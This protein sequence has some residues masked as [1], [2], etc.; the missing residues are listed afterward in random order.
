LFNVTNINVIIS[1]LKPLYLKEIKMVYFE[2]LSL[3]SFFSVLCKLSIYKKL[4]V[5]Y[6][7]DASFFANKLLIPALK[8]FGKKPVVLKFRINLTKNILILPLVYLLLT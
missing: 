2:N 8:F 3:I 1:L 5:F 4:G 7:I 6:F